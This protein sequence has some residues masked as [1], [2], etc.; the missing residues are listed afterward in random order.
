[1][2][3]RSYFLAG[4]RIAK[5]KH[6]DL[7]VKAFE[8]LDLPL[9][10]FGRGF[11]GAELT[12]KNS[13]IEFLGEVSDEEKIELMR[14]AKAFLFA[15]EDEDF[16]ITP[17]EAMS[18]GTPV[19]AYKSGGILET[20]VQGK[21][22]L[23]FEKLTVES[24]SAAIKQFNNLAINPKDCIEQAQKFSKERFKKEILNFVNSK[25]KK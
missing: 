23:F 15:A 17:V 20:V 21:T 12:S 24:L 4:G 1:M 9:K 10:V 16:G 2:S 18:V 3:P 6:I 14:G 5:P 7:I 8:K 22:G 13:N 11:A 25:I 19:V